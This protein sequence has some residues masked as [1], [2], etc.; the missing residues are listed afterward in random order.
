MSEFRFKQAVVVR[1]DLGLSPGKLA[2]QVAHA[3]ISA[4]DKSRWKKDWLREGQKK[5][6]LGVENLEELISIYNEAK[7][8][9]LPVELI[10]DL[11]KTEIPA[12]TKTCV[13][14]GP[15]PEEEI[16]KVTGELKLY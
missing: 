13:G 15:A 14:I 5:S 10:Q 2:A 8:S 4:A 12:G 1:R 11:G 7:N 16:D 3:A 9:G 6:V